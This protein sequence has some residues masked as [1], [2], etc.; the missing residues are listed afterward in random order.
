MSKILAING[1]KPVLKKSLPF[2]P[3][4]PMDNKE[5]KAVLRIMQSNRL[6]D[7]VAGNGEKFLGGKEIIDL[8]KTFTKKF[9]VKYSV[10]FNSATTA[11]HGAIVALGIGPGDEVIVPAY[12]MSA[13]ASC[14]L[15]NGAVPIFADIREDNYCIDPKSIL[16]NITPRTKAIIVVNLFGGSANFNEI[17]KIAE[18]HKLKIIEDNAQAPGAKYR[19]KFTGTIGD[20]GIFS[21]NTHK[22]IQSGEGGVLVTNN[23]KYSFRAQLARNHGECVVDQMDEKNKEIILG[24]NY[25]LT[26]IQA[27]IAKEQILKLDSLNR[28][29]IILADYLTSKLKDIPGIETPV[30]KNKNKH[31]YYIYPFKIKEEILGINRDKFVDAMQFEGFVLSKGYVKP[32]YLLPIYQKKKAF[33]NTSFPFKSMFYKGSPNYKKGICPVCERMYEKEFTFTTICQNPFTKKE[34]DLFVKAVKKIVNNKE[35]L[36]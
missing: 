16:K 11:L 9:K 12:S 19:G 21:F 20:I 33:N 14:V 26:N 25:R 3:P 10:S 22:V 2:F 31:V 30:L 7:F 24:S 6:S 27:V 28:Q 18:K 32:I 36:K 13:T 17:L 35:E 8:E 29:R 5:K 4:S 1:G 15:M 23:K 34:V